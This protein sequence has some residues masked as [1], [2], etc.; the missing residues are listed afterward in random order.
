MEGMAAVNI[1]GST[2][3]S[4][5]KII[6]NNGKTS[7]LHL[8]D[9]TLAR[10]R[11]DISSAS[12]SMLIVDEVSTIDARMIAMLDL[13]LQQIHNNCSSFGGVPVHLAGDFN[14]LGPVQKVFL[15][16]DMIDCALCLKKLGK[17][18]DPPIPSDTTLETKHTRQNAHA[19][20]RLFNALDKVHSAQKRPR[21]TQSQKQEDAANRF[22]PTS[23][24]HRGCFPF[25]SFARFHLKEQQRVQG[26]SHSHF[27]R[28]LSEG[29]PIHL[30]KI[31][32]CPPLSAEDV[33]QI[34]KSG[35]SRQHWSPAI[36][37]DWKSTE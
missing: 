25:S 19:E 35:C 10:I 11:D 1:D 28:H 36:M 15:P 3:P 32:E 30:H 4:M 20:D 14:Q 29:K 16:Q 17:L 12:M 27:V 6:E 7:A 21:R 8:D 13:R 9:D 24:T 23:L 31:L 37:S 26:D 18:N 33:N 2:I 5:F 34:Q 22:K